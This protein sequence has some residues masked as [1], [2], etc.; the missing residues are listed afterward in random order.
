MSQSSGKLV[1][2]ITIVAGLGLAQFRDDDMTVDEPSA[3]ST[4]GQKTT[5]NDLLEKRCAEYMTKLESKAELATR[6]PKPHAWPEESGFTPVS[7]PELGPVDRVNTQA[8]VVIDTLHASQGFGPVTVVQNTE[9]A[10]VSLA[11]GTTAQRRSQT[12]VQR[13]CSSNS[14]AR[15]ALHEP[16][17]RATCPIAVIGDCQTKDFS[18]DDLGSFSSALRE[19]SPPKSFTQRLW[20]A[21]SRPRQAGGVQT[22][23]TRQ[24]SSSRCSG[25]E[26][27]SPQQQTQCYSHPQMSTACD[28]T[29]AQRRTVGSV[30]EESLNG[31]LLSSSVLRCRPDDT[32]ETWLLQRPGDSELQHTTSSTQRAFSLRTSSLHR[33]TLTPEDGEA[34]DWTAPQHF[35]CTPNDMFWNCPALGTSSPACDGM[36]DASTEA[37]KLAALMADEEF[38]VLD[39]DE[40][41]EDERLCDTLAHAEVMT[42]LASDTA[43][44]FTGICEVDEITIRESWLGSSVEGVRR[45]PVDEYLQAGSLAL[46]SLSGNCK[47]P[48]FGI[49]SSMP[50]S[51]H[52][53]P[54]LSLVKETE[55]SITDSNTIFKPQTMR[56]VP[57]ECYSHPIAATENRPQNA[58]VASSLG[59]ELPP[60]E[61]VSCGRGM[62]SRG[63]GGSM[64]NSIGE[65]DVPHSLERT[66]RPP[67]LRRSATSTATDA[68]LHSSSDSSSAQSCRLALKKSFS[69]NS[70]DSGKSGV[71]DVVPVAGHYGSL[72]RNTTAA[73]ASA[74]CGWLP[75][76][77]SDADVSRAGL[78]PD[79][80][81]RQAARRGVDAVKAAISNMRENVSPNTA[82]SVVMEAMME[83]PL[84]SVNA[85]L[86]ES[87]LDASIEI[88]LLRKQKEA[89]KN[90]M[91]K[92]PSLVSKQAK[93]NP[94][95]P[96]K[97]AL[98]ES[99]SFPVVGR[100]EESRLATSSYSQVVRAAPS[101]STGF[102]H[103]TDEAREDGVANAIPSPYECD[104]YTELDDTVRLEPC[105]PSYTLQSSICDATHEQEHLELEETPEPSASAM[106]SASKRVSEPVNVEGCVVGVTTWLS[107][108]LYNP[109]HDPIR[110]L[111]KV[112]SETLNNRLV[113]N[114]SLIYKQSCVILQ[115]R[116]NLVWALGICARGEGVLRCSLELQLL[117]GASQR[118]LLTHVV[119][120]TAS[121]TLLQVTIGN[122][123]PLE[124]GCVPEGFSYEAQFEVHNN[125][126]R[127]LAVV[128]SLSQVFSAPV[129]RLVPSQDARVLSPCEIACTLKAGTNTFTMSIT[130]PNL[131]NVGGESKDS[132]KISC[133]LLVKLDSSDLP[134]PMLASE[135]VNVDVVAVHLHISRSC[136][137]L[138]LQ[139]AVDLHASAPLTLKNLSCIP[140]SLKLRCDFAEEHTSNANVAIVPDHF[141]IQPNM[142]ASPVVVFTPLGV[143]THF[144]ATVVIVVEPY[145]LE[146][147]VPVEAL[148]VLEEKLSDNNQEGKLLPNRENNKVTYSSSLD[149]C[150]STRPPAKVSLMNPIEASK[151]RLVFGCLKCGITGQQKLSFYNRNNTNVVLSFG[152]TGS[153]SFSVVDP[154]QN[155]SVVVPADG[156]AVILVAFS[157]TSDGP[158]SGML[159]CKPRGLQQHRVKYSI[160]LQGYGGCGELRMADTLLQLPAVSTGSPAIVRLAL[161]NAGTRT[162][163]V[164]ISS[165]AGVLPSL[166]MQVCCHLFLCR[167]VAISSYADV[168]CSTRVES[169]MVLP[170]ELL[171]PAA[172]C[173]DVVVVVPCLPDGGGSEEGNTCKS[174]K[175]GCLLVRYTEE[176][177]RRR[178]RNRLVSGCSKALAASKSSPTDW[179]AAFRSEKLTAQEEDG[180]LPSCPDDTK[181]FF[182]SFRQVKVPVLHSAPLYNS[183]E[184]SV[185][186]FSPLS[187]DYTLSDSTLPPPDHRLSG[188]PSHRANIPFPPAGVD[189][190]RN[191]NG[192][193]QEAHIN[194]DDAPS[195]ENEY[196]NK[197]I[198]QP[199]AL[200]T[201]TSRSQLGSVM[202]ENL[203]QSASNDLNKP[204]RHDSEEYVVNMDQHSSVQEKD[205]KCLPNHAVSTRVKPLLGTTALNRG[206]RSDKIAAPAGPSQASDR[207]N[208][209]NLSDCDPRESN[210]LEVHGSR[211]VNKNNNYSS[212]GEDATE[213]RHGS[214]RQ[215]LSRRSA[216]TMRPPRAVEL[217]SAGTESEC[218]AH[219]DKEEADGVNKT[220]QRIEAVTSNDQ[221]DNDVENK[222]NYMMHKN[223]CEAIETTAAP[224]RGSVE[225]FPPELSVEAG[226]AA[227]VVVV[228][229]TELRRTLHVSCSHSC[230]V[231]EPV[232]AT[233]GPQGSVSVRL[234]LQQ[235]LHYTTQASLTVKCN[236]HES[237]VKVTCL[238]YLQSTLS[239]ERLN[240]AGLQVG[241]SALSFPI[242]SAGKQAHVKLSLKNLSTTTKQVLASV[243]SG[244]GS[245]VVKHPH[246]QVKVGH[247]VNVP[248]Y[249]RPRYAGDHEGGL[250]LAVGGEGEVNVQLTG[251]CV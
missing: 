185:T 73:A 200:N 184:A 175:L 171:L 98:V 189:V 138:K 116:Q 172:C 92:Q 247:F 77:R 113:T 56:D 25:S 239:S 27:E 82:R 94:S 129:F 17:G 202:E 54:R 231:V 132:L 159:V 49:H 157:P 232:V 218:S 210:F 40:L 224:A 103:D 68:V 106:S 67:V 117:H 50:S 20:E 121:A 112:A 75:Q 85:T 195:R 251:S 97:A 191:L 134:R 221:P 79:L 219:P 147:E 124:V 61:L 14:S 246:F 39:M 118:P 65:K 243:V 241:Q 43:A 81:R 127:E 33:P 227:A 16:Q 209:N 230:L 179:D 62:R 44:H 161:S 205:K 55:T 234:T 188:W 236:G 208:E 80:L 145:G 123:M 173:Q 152:I 199:Y 42:S 45:V 95:M 151:S 13:Q 34:A 190:N 194:K 139:A 222:E 86:Q 88:D 107:V 122:A 114:S 5:R 248:V 131:C 141:M 155:N 115:P 10:P 12:T 192:P 15:T 186:C 176:V 193:N 158:H 24:E 177:L 7:W 178:Y 90:K 26:A 125:S 207:N 206:T 174:R 70:V 28:I 8:T 229:K 36:F 167:C 22:A 233:V 38:G 37:A 64:S 99:K 137:P 4:A 150:Q 130:V 9:L 46:G 109:T 104:E 21:K 142:L 128:L 91:S 6:A 29:A 216:N 53:T 119:P 211:N 244:G 102:V 108:P 215:V 165:Y 83:D 214:G 19:I 31:E 201:E 204:N 242:T 149:T 120:I 18:T 183:D 153:K 203:L 59:R 71:S 154:E 212:H 228:N 245:F 164:A 237:V 135:T 163:C 41:E 11:G 169:V 89:I 110:M 144:T 2:D 60:T 182:S 223:R 32:S 220:F 93:Y 52:S 226:G 181:V 100:S 87:V 225:V 23:S 240:V 187:V 51:V 126:G 66:H 72:G 48:S 168:E 101:S 156:T 198:Q 140:L 1:S 58:G 170:E 74:H 217:E 69:V 249:F 213:V 235:R 136:M 3:A 180:G 76:S 105:V 47:R 197:A 63:D 84:S 146:Y 35:N 96:R 148:S 111:A 166:L 250:R 160:Q 57:R 78:G 162:L 196:R 30:E 143:V 133:K 238:P